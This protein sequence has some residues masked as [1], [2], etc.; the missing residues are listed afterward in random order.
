MSVPLVVFLAIPVKY[1]TSSDDDDER[2]ETAKLLGENAMPNALGAK[3]SFA[4]IWGNRTLRK[5]IPLHVFCFAGMG[6]ISFTVTG[7][8]ATILQSKAAVDG[9]W[10]NIV[11]IASGVLTGIS[12]GATPRRFHA[13]IVRCMFVACSFALTMIVLLDRV[14]YFQDALSTRALG[15]LYYASMVVSGA[16][17][18]GFIGLALA[19]SVTFVQN[20]LDAMGI[21]LFLNAETFVGSIAE[22][23]LQVIAAVLVQCSNGEVG[24]VLLCAFSW[25]VTIV[26]FTTVAW[27]SRQSF[28]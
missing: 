7:I 13:R 24:F 10:A 19:S 8:S 4:A 25:M 18:L 12:A 11:F 1:D 6:G 2:E 15:A 5:Q 21:E 3:A 16:S 9:T 17:S 22:W 28:E 26:L 20:E 23:F 27:P 14:H